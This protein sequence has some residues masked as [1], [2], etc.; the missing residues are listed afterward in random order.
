MINQFHKTNCANQK[1]NKTGYGQIPV[2]GH[3]ARLLKSRGPQDN[4]L[5]E[6]FMLSFS[7]YCIFSV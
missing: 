3:Y 5:V 7:S 1:I 6:E 2:A 4:T